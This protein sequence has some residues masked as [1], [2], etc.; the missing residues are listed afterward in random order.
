MSSN[1]APMTWITELRFGT[2]RLISAINEQGKTS[3]ALLSESIVSRQESSAKHQMFQS[4][5]SFLLY[6]RPDSDLS[7]PETKTEHLPIDFSGVTLV[8]CQWKTDQN[9]APV[10]RNSSWKPVFMKKQ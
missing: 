9:L 3:L 10:C 7:H 6:S 1:L 4:A 8:L 5:L 2:K